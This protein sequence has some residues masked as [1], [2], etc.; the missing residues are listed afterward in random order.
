MV[1]MGH[2]TLL[3]GQEG[4]GGVGR[5]FRWGGAALKLPPQL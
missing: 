4:L 5:P 3:E 1:G 2:D